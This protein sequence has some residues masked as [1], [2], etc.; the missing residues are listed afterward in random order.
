ME[1]KE[2]LSLSRKKV[3]AVS[4]DFDGCLGGQPFIERYQELL[5]KYKIPEKIPP[6][7]YEKAIVEANQILFDH[8]KQISD[9][10]D[11]VILMV[12]SNRT[13]AQKDQ[14]DSIKNGNGSVFRAIEH[15]GSALSHSIDIPVEVN[16]RVVFDSVLHKKPG[17][18][19]DLK[20]E[21][22]IEDSTYSEYTM[23]GDNKYRL[24]Y[25]QIQE[26]CASHPDSEITYVHADDRDDIVTVSA[27]IYGNEK[28]AAMLPPNLEKASFLHYE[29]YNPIAELIRLQNEI[30]LLFERQKHTPIDEFSKLKNIQS[31]VDIILQ[32]MHALVSL[33]KNRLAELNTPTQEQITRAEKIL[34]TLPQ[35]RDQL[36]EIETIGD[37]YQ[38]IQDI[39]KVMRS[40]VSSRSMVLP[41]DINEKYSSEHKRLY[42]QKI[43][44]FGRFE[45]SSSH[46]GYTI[47]T[48]QYDSLVTL[49]FKDAYPRSSDPLSTIQQITI[50]SQQM[51]FAALAQKLKDA[52]IIKKWGNNDDKWSRMI[53]DKYQEITPSDK[54]KE[55][56]LKKLSNAIFSLKQ[57]ISNGELRYID[58]VPTLD[59]AIESAIK[60]SE[61][62]QKETFFGKMGVTESNVAKQLRSF[63]TEMLKSVESSEE[64]IRQEYGKT[65]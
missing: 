51:Q 10:Y 12:G 30:A 14:H 59:N 7:E 65:L 33:T 25:F 56:A 24:S 46:K 54:N 27:R 16:K 29:V 44:E 34:E 61:E 36:D 21:Q 4:I 26:V 13:S 58:A 52:L 40:N 39:N 31:A 45:R 49:C 9:G 1:S 41:P 20:T 3:L 37:L 2:D 5:E 35:L 32:D 23:S 57:N 43:A 60:K 18:N 17:H 6:E 48:H 38:C 28:M 47:P 19:F 55:A 62:T 11:K 63:Q 42:Q 15:L 53:I 64:K 8:I 22:T 50:E